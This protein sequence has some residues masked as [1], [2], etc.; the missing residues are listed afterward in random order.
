[1]NKAIKNQNDRCIK[2]CLPELKKFIKNKRKKDP[3]YG[4]G[5]DGLFENI[6]VYQVEPNSLN[7]KELAKIK[8]FAL[9][10]RMP[11]RL[12]CEYDEVAKYNHW[13]KR[14]WYVIDSYFDGYQE[15]IDVIPEDLGNIR[16]THYNKR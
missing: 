6:L 12:L 8:H 9:T 14:K 5:Y 3:S 16:L 2:H 10:G 1:M 4:W 11:K 7:H 15:I 13:W